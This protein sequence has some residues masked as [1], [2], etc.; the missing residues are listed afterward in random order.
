MKG[1]YSSTYIFANISFLMEIGFT[2][3]F[4]LLH[5]FFA[6]RSNKELKFS[7]TRALTAESLK[8]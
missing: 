8:Y 7:K 5:V 1:L 3:F 4:V 6:S 2:Y